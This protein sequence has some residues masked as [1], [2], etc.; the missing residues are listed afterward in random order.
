[1]NSALGLCSR[2][3]VSSTKCLDVAVGSSFGHA[4]RLVVTVRS[5][6]QLLLAEPVLDRIDA[7]R[8]HPT[9]DGTTATVTSRIESEMSLYPLKFKPRFVEKMWGGRK[10]ETVL[11]KPLPAGKPIGE[12]W[13][14]YDF[15]PGVVDGIE[16]LGQRRDRQRP[17]RRPD[18]ALSSSRNSARD[19]HGDVPLSGRTGSFRS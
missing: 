9:D 15:P 18:A 19:L 10:L 7:Y 12:S 4:V 5:A 11:G 16:R 3:L 6:S 2:T 14:L 8:C 17:A 1:M 13:E